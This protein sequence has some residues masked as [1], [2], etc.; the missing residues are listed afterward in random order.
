MKIVIET[1][2]HS[3]QRYE[4]PGDYWT[5]PDGTIQIRISEMGDD[6]SEKLVAVHELVEVIL[7]DK[8]GISEQSITDFDIEFEN[9]RKKG[10]EDEPGFDNK[11]PYKNEHAIATS[12]ELIMCAHLGFS[13]KDYEDIVNNVSH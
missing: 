3:S 6:L 12:V 5:D 2:P 4:T 9:N 11:S 13:W 10:N 1:I 7:T 8:K